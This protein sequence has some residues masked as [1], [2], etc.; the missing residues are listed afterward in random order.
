MLTVAFSVPILR[1]L[2]IQ[3][4]IKTSLFHGCFLLT[5]PQLT[6]DSLHIQ[7]SSR[8]YKKQYLALKVFPL[9]Q[10]YRIS[11]ISINLVSVFC[12]FRGFKNRVASYDG[13]GGALYESFWLREMVTKSRLSLIIAFNVLGKSPLLNMQ[14]CPVS[15]V[16][17]SKL[18]HTVSDP[19]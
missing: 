2:C 4:L 13:S 9:D 18:N 14:K 10:W 6:P 16:L 3:L 15:L 8:N 7:F 12:F 1:K 11:E 19:H 5:N 17:L